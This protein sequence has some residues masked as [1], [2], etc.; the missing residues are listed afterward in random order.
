MTW[1]KKYWKQLLIAIFAGFVV[2]SAVSGE[3]WSDYAN[4][5]FW[6]NAWLVWQVICIVGIIVLWA[7]AWGGKKNK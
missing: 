5:P 7:I 6:Q 2:L 3:G 4:K 1:L